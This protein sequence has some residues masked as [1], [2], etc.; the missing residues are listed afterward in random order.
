MVY[1]SV[2]NYLDCGKSAGTC[3]GG[4]WVHAFEWAATTGVSDVSC[5]PCKG[6]DGVCGPD[7]R[8]MCTLCFENRTC[9]PVPGARRFHVGEWGYVNASTYGSRTS[10][11]ASIAAMQAEIQARGPLVCSMQTNDDENPLGAWHCY[12]GGVYR[13]HSTFKSTNHVINLLGWGEEDGV[14]F[15]VGPSEHSV[16]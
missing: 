9:V 11:A 2:Q 14:P 3:R 5:A 16:A 8:A 12:E 4:S 15:W 10:D 6:V 1:L 7:E 13:T